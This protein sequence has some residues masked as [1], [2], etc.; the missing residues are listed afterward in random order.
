MGQPS[1]RETEVPYNHPRSGCL[2]KGRCTVSKI[3]YVVINSA[4]FYLQARIFPPM[5]QL[6]PFP[7]RYEHLIQ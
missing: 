4:C 5:V 1:V 6:E 3:F 7:Q 2:E